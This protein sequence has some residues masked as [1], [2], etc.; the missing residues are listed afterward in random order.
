MDW[1]SDDAAEVELPTGY[2]QEVVQTVFDNWEAAAA[3]APITDNYQGPGLPDG[4]VKHD[5]AFYWEDPG[6][7][8]GTG[9]LAL[10]VYNGDGTGSTAG[11][12]QRYNIASVA[13]IFQNGIDWATTQE[14][15][16]GTCANQYAIEPLVSHEMGHLWGL[17]DVCDDGE[18]CTDLEMASVMSTSNPV[19][20]NCDISHMLPNSDDA[21]GIEALYGPEI[22]VSVGTEA[23]ASTREGAVP[24]NV[25]FAASAAASSSD[26]NIAVTAVHWTFGDGSESDE[27]APCHTYESEAQFT[28]TATV[29]AGTDGGAECPMPEQTGLGYITACNA[30]SPELGADGLFAISETSGLTW[31]TINHTEMTTDGCVDTIAWQVYKGTT[32]ADITPADLVTIDG[33]TS[34]GAWAPA[35]TFPEAGDYLVVLNIG[36]PGGLVASF[37]PVHVTDTGSGGCATVP[38]GPGAAWL[39][40]ALALLGLARRKQWA[41]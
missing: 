38:N 28:V 34:T 3:C 13:M 30:P 36:G 35:I 14:V 31:Q 24:L 22:T 29:S 4:A 2:P 10:T 26:P 39:A 41:G 37:L 23:D 32:E 17:D 5:A 16:D 12:E 9:V 25:C 7:D 18:S 1:W 33:E 40:G 8:L 27:L 6:H 19:G 15:E 11:G 20:A 21:A